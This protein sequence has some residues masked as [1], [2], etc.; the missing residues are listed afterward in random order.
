MTASSNFGNVFSVLIASIFLPFLPMLSVQLL[1]QNLLYDIS[2]I[3]IP[4]D[5]VDHEYLRQPRKWEANGIVRFMLFIGPLSS[6]FDV[7]TFLVLWYVLKA[8]SPEQADF[9]RSGWFVQGLLSQTLIVH[10]I[11]TKKIPFFQSRAANPVILLTLLVMAIGILIPFTSLGA[12]LG[13]V[14]LPM[15][16]FACLAGILTGYC[17]LLQLVKVW[18]IRKFGQWL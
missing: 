9:F 11:R 12:S 14:P 6:I 7:I 17:I 18:Y 2:Q 1:V 16:Y 8:N 3:S 10:M 13:L 5:E 4:W 15:I